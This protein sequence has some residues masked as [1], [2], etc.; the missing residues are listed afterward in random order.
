[1]AE[2]AVGQPGAEPDAAEE[3]GSHGQ[4]RGP[5]EIRFSAESRHQPAEVTWLSSLR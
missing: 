1:M 4:E 2:L 5:V 3:T